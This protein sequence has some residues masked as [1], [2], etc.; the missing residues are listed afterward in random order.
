[1]LYLA[2]GS[3]LSHAQMALRCPAARPVGP[4]LLHGWRLRFRHVANA[5]AEAGT[6]LPGALWRLTP[7]CEA[8]LDAFEGVAGGYYRRETVVAQT[9]EGRAAALVYVMDGRASE[10]VAP[11]LPHYRETIERGY[12]DFG[13]DAHLPV[14]RAAL[15]EAQAARPAMPPT[16][17][18]GGARTSATHPLRI[19]RLAVGPGLLGLALCPGQRRADARG[20][21]WAR[22]L[23]ADLDVVRRW[24]A[25]AVVTLLTDEELD[26]LGVPELA[27]AVRERGMDWHHLP[28]APGGAMAHGTEVEAVVAKTLARGGRVLVHG[29]S[30]LDRTGRF[31]ARILARTGVPPDEAARM[32][33]AVRPGALRDP[34]KA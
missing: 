25:S 14:L 15:A 30:G 16:R 31:A 3:N 8:T 2:Y 28:T 6:V 17:S 13:L 33:R 32:V 9:R 10:P 5:E 1:M 12:A 4:A 18:E 22:D 20:G 27:A 29:R 19:D 26:A 21:P 7:A 34:R 24:H 23:A 11:P